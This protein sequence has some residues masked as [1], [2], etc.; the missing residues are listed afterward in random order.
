M[1]KACVSEGSCVVNA[2]LV[3]GTCLFIG[4]AGSDAQAGKGE[5]FLGGLQRIFVG[6]GTGLGKQGQRVVRKLKEELPGDVEVKAISPGTA[7]LIERGSTEHE[8]VVAKVKDCATCVTVQQGESMTV[9]PFGAK[10]STVM[11]LKETVGSLYLAQFPQENGV[12]LVDQNDPTRKSRLFRK[13]DKELE[14]ALLV[15][16]G[17]S[18][19]V[20][21]TKADV[22]K[23]SV[24]FEKFIG[25]RG[26]NWEVKTSGYRLLISSGLDREQGFFRQVLKTFGGHL[27]VENDLIVDED[28]NNQSIISGDSLQRSRKFHHIS[29]VKKDGWEVVDEDRSR[30]FIPKSNLEAPTLL[31]QYRHHPGAA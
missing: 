5:H 18:Q 28:R 8:K 19:K 23:A 15:D 31:F 3:A 10:P 24:Q 13:I 22:T 12:R 26:D 17:R 7:V 29:K 20:L 6:P 30:W 9:H 11:T 14:G 2:V 27:L 21:I 16:V 4:F 25:R 1:S